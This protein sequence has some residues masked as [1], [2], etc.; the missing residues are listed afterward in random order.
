MN[1][2][3]SLLAISAPHPYFP[4]GI[5]GLEPISSTSSLTSNL[6]NP[7]PPWLGPNSST[8]NLTSNII[9]NS[10]I[11]SAPLYNNVTAGEAWIIPASD[12]DLG[13][14]AMTCECFDPD[15]E[16]PLDHYFAEAIM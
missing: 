2:T 16:P 6:T 14:R 10:T 9:I 3:T 7:G 13:A 15:C 4:T 5:P 8:N 11:P 12:Y 1:I